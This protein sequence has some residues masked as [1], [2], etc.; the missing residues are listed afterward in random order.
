MVNFTPAAELRQHVSI[1]MSSWISIAIS[2]AAFFVSIA[3]W[4][5]TYLA[6]FKLVVVNSA[7]RFSIYGN[8]PDQGQTVWWIP[9]I[10]MS[11][12]FY[13]VGSKFG[14]VEDVRMSVEMITDE[15]KRTT[16][17]FYVRWI[18][19]PVQFNKYH[20]NRG[21]IFEETIIK[22][23]FPL[24]L[25]SGEQQVVHIILEGGR[26]RDRRKAEMAIT[27]EIYSSQFNKWKEHAQYRFSLMPDIVRLSWS[28]SSRSSGAVLENL[29]NSRLQQTMR[30]ADKTGGLP[31]DRLSA[32]PYPRTPALLRSRC[33]FA[34]RSRLT[35]PGGVFGSVPGFRR[36]RRG[37]WC[38]GRRLR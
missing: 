4:W 14:R 36:R 13:N 28:R 3:T 22:S 27:L 7:P 19:D 32:K 15:N 16:Y 25:K 12:A 20:S 23:W 17:P 24:L 31:E 26:W 6:P 10:D 37:C 8:T 5:K 33:A 18:V 1:P 34:A 2:L 9:S 35:P 38:R 30:A 11:F 29:M 21:W